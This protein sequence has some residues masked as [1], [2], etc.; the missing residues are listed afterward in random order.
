MPF[1]FDVQ[2]PSPQP[3]RRVLACPGQE[4]ADCMELS[5]AFSVWFMLGSCAECFGEASY[6]IFGCRPLPYGP[7][8]LWCGLHDAPSLHVAHAHDLAHEDT[9]HIEQRTS[10]ILDLKAG[11]PWRGPQRRR[12]RFAGTAE[13]PRPERVGPCPTRYLPQ[14]PPDGCLG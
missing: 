3:R 10:D 9:L 13:Q 6:H 2:L 5:P 8:G 12:N 14:Q 11:F 1:R 7:A 4:T